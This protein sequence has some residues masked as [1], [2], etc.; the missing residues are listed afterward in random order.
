MELSLEL[1]ILIHIAK[2]L[3]EV[4]GQNK[5]LAAELAIT[6]QS[7]KYLSGKNK[8]LRHQLHQAISKNSKSSSFLKT[9]PQPVA[10]YGDVVQE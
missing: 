8:D 10:S 6:K 3:S 1:F 4:K 5:Y 2:Y 9:P 7:M